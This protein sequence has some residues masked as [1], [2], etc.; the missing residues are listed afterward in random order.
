MTAENAKNIIKS[1]K[2]IET[3]G[4]YPLK[5][6]NV[7]SY[8]RV[9]DNTGELTE[10]KIVNFSAMT[11]W[12]LKEAVELFKEGK[13]QEATNKSVAA[14]LRST[15]YIPM[16]GEIVNVIMDE[17]TT[18]N[19]ITGLFPISVTEIAS[20]TTKN[21][22]FDFEFEDVKIPTGEPADTF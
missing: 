22:S 21:V 10:I 7:T 14:S 18:K 3:P 1:R 9:N 5:V 19:G 8:N 16:K 20:K 4:K 13:F 15:D 2:M 11:S 12:H 17:I 6:T